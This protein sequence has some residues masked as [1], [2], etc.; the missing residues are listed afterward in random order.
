M[1]SESMKFIFII[2]LLLL[3]ITGV[4]PAG[5]TDNTSCVI[6]VHGLGRTKLSM[7]NVEFHLKNEGYKVINI[8][9]PS[10]EYKIQTLAEEYL[11]PEVDKCGDRDRIHFVTHSLGGIIT[12]YYLQKYNT[13][14]LGRV[15]MLSPPNQGTEIADT[16]ADFRL[17]E[18]THGPVIEQL[19][20]EADFIE[21]L[22]PVDYEVGIITG[23]KSYNFLNSLLIPGEDDGKV[24]ID[25]AKV[26]N[27]EDFLVVPRTHTF[28][29]NSEYVL[30][31]IDAFLSRG[32]F[33]D[34][35]SNAKYSKS[36]LPAGV[37]MDL[38]NLN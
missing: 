36:L 27:M 32:T 16:V 35:L 31:Q 8:Q 4:T 2:F 23:N 24:G 12:R 37:R 34:D 28:I 22:E 25:N 33:D 9:Y 7:L 26:T 38:N 17:V 29:M 18:W 1:L 19:Q 11:K 6:L 15:V 10:T 3:L 13:E 5:A 14:N 21:K 20:T 30:K